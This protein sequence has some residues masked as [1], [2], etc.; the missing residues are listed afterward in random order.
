[1]KQYFFKVPG[2]AAL[3]LTLHSVCFS[4]DTPPPPP[5][6]AVAP[7]LPNENSEERGSQD[8]IIIRKKNDK[9]SKIVIE[10]KNGKAF[11]NGKPAEEFNDD[12]VIIIQKKIHGPEEEAFSFIA[13]NAPS[14]P[15]RGG[16]SYSGDDNLMKIRSTN[17]AFLGVSSE[18]TE[19]KGAKITGITEGSAAEKAAL[20]KGDI[21]SK[22]NDAKIGNPEELTAA[23]HK[24]K[25]EDKVTV[26]YT[27]EGKEQKTTATLGKNKLMNL[28]KTYNFS[29]PRM[30]KLKEL[31][32]LDGMNAPYSFSWSNDKHRLGIKAQDTE[33]GKGAKVLDVDDES[34]ADNAG[35]K[36]GDIITQFD[37]KP[38]NSAET[39]A[40][41]ARE[42]KDK[43]SYKIN[44]SRDGKTQEVEIKI[45][46]KL[47][48]A[49]L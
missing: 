7:A 12:N 40:N 31:S 13:P 36:E 21:I 6:P 35:V 3:V 24:L 16:W 48:T 26:T 38:V 23:I 42:N 14:S 30:E 47:K 2:I 8:E 29:M 19:G 33:D 46:K 9:D 25:P 22:I 32:E 5:P 15:F 18:S 27:R 20:R 11:I 10:I 34:P 28:E 1:M 43:S 17:T 4:Q 45:P 37:G 44:L 39:L 41:L 49:D